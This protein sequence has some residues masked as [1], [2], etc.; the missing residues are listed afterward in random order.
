MNIY[1]STLAHIHTKTF[2][3]AQTQNKQELQQRGRA[4]VYPASFSLV[5]RLLTTPQSNPKQLAIGFDYKKMK[6]A[7]ETLA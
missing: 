4:L 2:K 7:G 3:H 6:V 1:A 5:K